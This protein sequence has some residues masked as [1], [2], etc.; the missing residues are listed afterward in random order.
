[1]SFNPTKM[2]N[3]YYAD[4][5]NQLQKWRRLFTSNT[6]KDGP[7]VIFSRLQMAISLWV[8][9]HKI[10]RSQMDPTRAF[11]HI[12][13]VYCARNTYYSLPIILS[14]IQIRLAYMFIY[15]S[16]IYNYCIL[17][18]HTFFFF[19]PGGVWT[20]PPQSYVRHSLY[21]GL[22]IKQ[23]SI[24]KCSLFIHNTTA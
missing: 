20:R 9:Y 1:M 23:F 6:E 15:I 13:S 5:K 12:F 14:S 21:I 4:N 24:A 10:M 19:G 16:Y 8:F 22:S 7:S 18:C 11:R 2:K 3:T 17:G